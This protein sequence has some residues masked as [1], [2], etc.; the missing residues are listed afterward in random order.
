M[1]K[2]HFIGLV[3]LTKIFLKK[4]ITKFIQIG[5]CAEY[6][7]AHAPQN[8]S[9]Q[10]LPN[11][12]YALAKLAATRFSLMLYISKK[13]PITILRFFQV[14]GPQQDQNRALP[15]RL[16][17]YPLLASACPRKASHVL[18]RWRM[19]QRVL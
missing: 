19:D 15:H 11:S 9:L 8:E 14:Y 16:W 13:F 18:I 2:T 17:A 4:K 12:P 10:C 3:N 5:S 6:G 1:K 7:T